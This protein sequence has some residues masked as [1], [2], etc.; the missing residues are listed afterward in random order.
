[1]IG[2]VRGAVA[3]WYGDDNY[4]FTLDSLSDPPDGDDQLIRIY[5]VDGLT[6]VGELDSNMHLYGNGE[7]KIGIEDMKIIG[8]TLYVAS[9]YYGILV[10]DIKDLLKNKTSPE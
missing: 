2:I 6:L 1:M 4:L 10:F 8:N 3:E 9:G 7:L 5:A